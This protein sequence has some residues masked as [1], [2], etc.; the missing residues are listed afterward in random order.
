MEP[1]TRKTLI[2]LHEVEHLGA[3]LGRGSRAEVRLVRHKST[4]SELALKT[5]DLSDASDFESASRP[6]LEECAVHL[7]LSHPNIVR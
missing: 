5:V 7:P 2:G 1:V 4:G 3:K 6:V